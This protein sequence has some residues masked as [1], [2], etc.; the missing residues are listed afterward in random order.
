MFCLIAK[1]IIFISLSKA[2]IFTGGFILIH[3]VVWLR[4]LATLLMSKLII[5]N[6]SKFCETVKVFGLRTDL[7]LV[8]RRCYKCYN[9]YE[10]ADN[11][12]SLEETCLPAI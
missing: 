8:I 3:I 7:P 5:K 1:R 6:V 4:V 12:A 10:N 9:P 11:W 2:L